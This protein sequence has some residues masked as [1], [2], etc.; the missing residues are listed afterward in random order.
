MAS[1]IVEGGER[2]EGE[3]NVSGSKNA[4]LPIIAASILSGKTTTLYNVPNIY[5]TKTTLE[6]LKL[7]GCT[8]TKKHGKI[9][10]D[11][12]N[13]KSQEIPN[14]LMRKMRSSVILAGAILGRFKHAIFSYP[15]GCDIGTRP[16]DLHLKGFEKLGIKIEEGSGY[17]KCSCDKIVGNNIQLDFPSVGATENI[18]LASIFAEGETIITNA[19]MEPEI[20]D[21]QNFLNKMGA[22]V[23]GA[24]T[25]V[26]KIT[27]VKNLKNVSY[28]IMPDRIEAGTLLC[29]GAI[30][31]GELVLNNAKQE[32]IT[33]VVLESRSGRIDT[34]AAFPN[35]KLNRILIQETCTPVKIQ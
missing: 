12:K 31:G 2:L 21:L 29:M 18:I 15:G 35:I 28:N 23:E 26:I 27:G 7:L 19:A 1:Y 25:N 24:G 3:V 4:S 5:D 6:I 13:I 16:I 32:H 9:I 33:P 17:I 8:V 14:E 34:Q 10:I 11:S 20:I 22:K 30:S